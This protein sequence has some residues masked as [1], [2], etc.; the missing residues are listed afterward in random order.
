MDCG[1]HLVAGWQES[2]KDGKRINRYCL[3]ELESL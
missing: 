3:L 2:I 1:A